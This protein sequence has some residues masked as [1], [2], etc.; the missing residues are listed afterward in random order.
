MEDVV[1]RAC[2]GRQKGGVL[3]VEVVEEAPDDVTA[4]EDFSGRQVRPEGS[5]RALDG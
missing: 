4:V 5:E 2:V 1:L 3:E